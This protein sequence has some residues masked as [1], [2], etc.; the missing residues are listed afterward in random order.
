MIGSRALAAAGVLALVVVLGGGAPRPEVAHAARAAVL[1]AADRT[2]AA[3]GQLEEDLGQA[4][5]AGR[6][7]AARVV[8][9][10]GDPAER[11]VAAGERALG[12]AP[13]ANALRDALRDLE[14]ARNAR[15]PVAVPL[16]P[17]P[18]ATELLSISGQLNEAA[19]AGTDF[20]EMRRRAEALSGE[21]VDAL[22]AAAD[23]R[24][25][26]ADEQLAAALV[27]VDEVREWEEVNRVLTVWVDTAD[28][29]IRAMQRLVDAVR[30]GAPERA[31]AARAAFDDAARDSVEADRSLR[32]GL[33]E[34]GSAQT[35]VPLRRLA[36]LLVELEELKSDVGAVREGVG[37]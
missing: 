16:P 17:A 1:G 9:G 18:D 20:A 23:G 36:R 33:G 21:L 22:D 12:A 5:D 28:A 19:A 32:I 3:I 7:G 27:V 35:A 6:T 34:V 31:A 13:S 2:I 10:D 8:A 4:V 29:M 24:L 37:A 14:R 25:E 30:A 26:E 11:L 15:D